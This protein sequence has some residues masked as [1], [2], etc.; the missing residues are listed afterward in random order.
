MIKLRDSFCFAYFEPPWPPVTKP[1]LNLMPAHEHMSK[2]A[3]PVLA[4]AG[5]S[6]KL[7]L[8]Q[9]R[10]DFAAGGETEDLRFEARAASREA[11]GVLRSFAIEASEQASIEANGY[12]DLEDVERARPL[13]AAAKGFA[14]YFKVD[15]ALSPAKQFEEVFGHPL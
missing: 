11:N 9:N 6:S 15:A 13:V 12:L 10:Y 7:Q 1:P 3:G 2:L 5:L 14:E 8:L 4:Y